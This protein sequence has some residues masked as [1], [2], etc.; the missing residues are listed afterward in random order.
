MTGLELCFKGDEP[1]IIPAE[2]IEKNESC[3]GKGGI[4]YAIIT[5]NRSPL[6]VPY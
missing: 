6:T 3:W 5:P 2:D 4:Y 1:L